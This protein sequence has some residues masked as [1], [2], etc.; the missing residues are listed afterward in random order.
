MAA[1]AASALETSC[2]S[3]LRAPHDTAHRALRN[4]A[5]STSTVNTS[6]ST[7]LN[8]DANVN[9]AA[10]RCV[11]AVHA[12]LR[13]SKQAQEAAR[14]LIQT[15][16]ESQGA[17][18]GAEGGR[19][20]DVLS[21]LRAAAGIDEAS[22]EDLEAQATVLRSLVDKESQEFWPR[23]LGAVGRSVSRFAF[24]A[25]LS[26]LQSESGS[27]T[28]ESWDRRLGQEL[29]GRG[30][31]PAVGAVDDDAEHG[32]DDEGG[33][34][35][36]LR[37]LEFALPAG[38]EEAERLR[39]QR[40]I[41]DYLLRRGYFASAAVLCGA[42]PADALGVGKKSGKREAVAME[43]EESPFGPPE[44][45]GTA[46]EQ[47]L[48]ALLDVD[49][50]FLDT[51]TVLRGLEAHNTGPALAW[52]ESNRHRLDVRGHTLEFELHLQALIELVR[53]VHT[54]EQKSEA[55]EFARSH[56]APLLDDRPPH[57]DRPD[58]DFVPDLLCSSFA[59]YA[60][61]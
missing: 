45:A 43:H 44:S 26:N 50:V 41:G 23:E 30:S 5:T 4:A 9:S 46:T 54:K 59:P 12:R 29:F 42:T 34:S 49:D 20:G 18:D 58:G 35:E 37:L 60:H 13:T 40:L 25:R 10:V 19:N 57:P 28:R 22:A 14:D 38:E 8:K 11:N 47:L 16:T 3:L 31:S 24:A 53:S 39:V 51:R 32:A 7:D 36:L 17:D 6:T 48:R 15:G 21:A 1:S 52:C 61:P 56:L 2:A 33:A 27:E 55:L